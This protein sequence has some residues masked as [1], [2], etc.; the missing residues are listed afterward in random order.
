MMDPFDYPED[1][2]LYGAYIDI[3]D[4]TE[5]DL[6]KNVPGYTKMLLRQMHKSVEPYDDVCLIFRMAK[7]DA[8][9]HFSMTAAWKCYGRVKNERETESEGSKQD[10]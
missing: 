9:S 6:I 1:V 10:D 4:T 3:P 5:E 7:K 2:K 8:K